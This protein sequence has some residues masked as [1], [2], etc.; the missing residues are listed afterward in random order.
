MRTG[1]DYSAGRIDAEHYVQRHGPM[2]AET[3]AEF[4]R[5]WAEDSEAY[6]DGF[7]TTTRQLARRIRGSYDK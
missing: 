7:T 4:L 6:I 3:K 2:A 1:D 5:T